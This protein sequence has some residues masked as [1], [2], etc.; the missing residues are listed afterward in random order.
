MLK[1]RYIQAM[2]RLAL[3][4]DQL[5]AIVAAM[6][7]QVTE[8][9][10]EKPRRPLLRAVLLAAAL[11]LTLAVTTLAVS[12]T[13]RETL[14]AALGTFAPYRQETEGPCVVDQ[15][16]ELKVVS[17][18]CDGN[19]A[20][21]YVELRDLTGDR[22]DEFTQCDLD[23][24]PANWSEE[25]DIPWSAIGGG[26]DLFRYDPASK[27]ILACAELFG[28]G[29]P[30]SRLTLNLYM[31]EIQPGGALD[32]AP[33]AP[34]IRGEWRLTVE[35]EMVERL[36]IDMLPSQTFIAGVTARTLH[37][38]TL[39]ATLESDANG[40]PNGLG[41][42]LTVYLSDGRVLPPIK[43]PPTSLPSSF[44]DDTVSRWTFPEPVEPEDVVAI[45]IGQWYVPL[46]DGTAQ[47]GHWLPEQP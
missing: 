39:G 43:N 47:P 5:N 4:P 42:P 38:S 22:L 11:C 27:T 15:D 32:D 26:G 12:P 21:V 40:T 31:T 9:R 23:I 14:L 13:L 37:L 35:A 34:A 20:K 25:G 6:D 8:P 46:T 44:S 10:V 30:A 7:R 3:S 16:I 24:M 36:S 41:Y 18:L 45:A 29:P 19:S 2:D 28:Y 33:K 17:T 1:E